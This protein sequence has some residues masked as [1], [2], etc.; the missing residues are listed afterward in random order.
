MTAPRAVQRGFSLL[1]ILVAFAILALSLGALYRAT[2]GAVRSVSHIETQQRVLALLQSVL[3]GVDGVPEHGL[4]EQG[5]ARDLHWSL[6]SSPYAGG[7]STPSVP[8]L[9]EV[10]ATVTWNEDGRERQMQ[11]AT[12]RPQLGPITPRPQP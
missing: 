4:A 8:A 9:H 11:L 10:Q 1:E 2:G 3:A 5:E 12:L 6:R 7:A